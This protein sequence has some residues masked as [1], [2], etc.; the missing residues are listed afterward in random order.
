[1]GQLRFCNTHECP[2]YATDFVHGV[3]FNFIPFHTKLKKGKVFE[4]K[5]VLS[6][7]MSV[8]QCFQI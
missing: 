8:Y 7:D 3:T 4:V 6:D 5:V 2:F 1:M